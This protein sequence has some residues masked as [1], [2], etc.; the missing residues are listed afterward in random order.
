MQKL[1]YATVS[2]AVAVTILLTGCTSAE[3]RAAA[4]AA[5][6]QRVAEQMWEADGNTGP[7]PDLS[8]QGVA[9]HV[10]ELATLTNSI[11][12]N[13]STDAS[14]SALSDSW[15]LIHLADFSDDEQQSYIEALKAPLSQAISGCEDGRWQDAMPN[16]VEVNT[17]AD[18][19][20]KLYA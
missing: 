7:L 5:E 19:Y 2:I 11:I 13:G 17:M 14:C 4:E 1:S 6:D 10:S 3:D 18:A 20:L 12:M 9:D 8:A 16:V 15:D